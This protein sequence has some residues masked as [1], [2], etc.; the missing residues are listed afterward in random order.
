[1]ATLWTFGDSLTFGHGCRPDGPINEYYYNYRSE[2]DDIWPNLFGKMLNIEVKNLGKCGAS[3]DFIIDSIIDN[4]DMIKPNDV[5]I[6]EKSFYQRFDIPK[7]NNDVFDTYCAED[8]NL[9]N[10]NLKRNDDN[11]NKLEIETILNY[12]ILF[13]DHFL[14]KERQN[15]RF[16]FIEK[17]LNSKV[18]KILIWDAVDFTNNKIDTIRNHTNGKIKDFH[19]S[20]KGHQ[21]FSEF[22]YKKLYIKPELI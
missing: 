21:L 5:V 1:M 2:L 7:L 18:N 8:L 6:I 17:Q 10:I 22:L 14:F 9:I 11:K 19:F 3:N 12:G 4:F 20:F 15:K 16:K 13:C